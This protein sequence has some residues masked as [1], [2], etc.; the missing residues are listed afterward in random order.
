MRVIAILL[1]ILLG[2]VFIF[3]GYI[4]IHP[5]EPFEYS[6]VELGAGWKSS[7]FFARLIIGL[8]F[9]CGALLIFNL[10]LRRFTI[11]LVTV[12]LLIFT[13]YLTLQLF[14]FGN[15]GNCGCFGNKLPMTPAQGIIKNIIMMLIGG[16][17]YLKHPGFSI[18]WMKP[19]VIVLIIGSMVMPFILNPVDFNAASKNYSGELNYKL[20]L[21]ILYNDP[22]NQPPKVELRKGKWVIAFVSLTCPHCRVAGKKLHL[23]MKKNPSLP[24]HMV[25]NG[26]EENIKP[27]FEETHAENVSWSMFKGPENFVKLAGPSLPQIIW[28]NNSIVENKSNYITLDQED[29][30]EWLAK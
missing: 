12:V 18:R 13:I 28:V 23:F 9:A 7:V 3:S 26:S 2:A 15:A 29:V 4:K 14:K 24:I 8:E 17:I 5:I 27:F 22:N 19:A 11:P 20:D 25:M 6:F 1:S 21:D 10:W 30:E 16:L